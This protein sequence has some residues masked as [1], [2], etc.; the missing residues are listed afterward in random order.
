MSLDY[1]FKSSDIAA[2]SHKW[3]KIGVILAMPCG[4]IPTPPNAIVSNLKN[5]EF[6]ERDPGILYYTDQID[7]VCNW[8]YNYRGYTEFAI[9]CLDDGKFS[10]DQ[11][12]CIS[13]S[14]SFMSSW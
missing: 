1:S 8:G 10:D 2:L 3:L 6:P 5:I 7:Y 14:Q 11:P 9:A 4:S 13:K 12:E